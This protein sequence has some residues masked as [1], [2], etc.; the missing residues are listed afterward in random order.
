[1]S[2]KGSLWWGDKGLKIDAV[3]HAGTSGILVKA[4]ES[5]YGRRALG[6]LRVDEAK[7]SS[8]H[9]KGLLSCSDTAIGKQGRFKIEK[10]GS[11]MGVLISRLPLRNWRCRANN[12]FMNLGSQPVNGSE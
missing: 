8:V 11:S 3:R 4:K 9:A 5:A 7:P 6:I 2:P 1:V 10:L 12:Q